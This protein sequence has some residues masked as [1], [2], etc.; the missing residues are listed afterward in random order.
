MF[1]ETRIILTNAT[2]EA[3][4]VLAGLRTDLT[5]KEEETDQLKNKLKKAENKLKELEEA[6]IK[7]MK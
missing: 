5:T 3:K 6:M 7:L 2:N 1:D 4:N